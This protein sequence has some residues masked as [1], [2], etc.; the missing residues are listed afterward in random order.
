MPKHV[1][2]VKPDDQTSKPLVL[3]FSTSY[4]PLAGGAEIALREIALRLSN[5]FEFMILTART[6][7]ENAS[8]ELMPEGTVI[9]IGMGTFFDKWML[10]IIVP[11]RC[12]SIIR[13]AE[14]Q[15][16]DVILW[17]MDITQASLSAAILNRLVLA[18]PMILTIQYGEDEG[19][20]MQ[21]RLG[22]IRF[23]LRFLLSRADHVIAIS[24]YLL[25]LAHDHGYRGRESLIPN[26]VDVSKFENPS[27]HRQ[28]VVPTVI[29]TSRLVRKNGVDTLIRAIGEIVDRAPEIK[30]L[31]L[32]NGQLRPE[33]ETLTSD[34]GLDGQIEFLGDVAHAEVPAH[35]WASDIFVRPSRSEGMGNSFVEALAAGLP[36]IGTPVGGIPDIIRDGETGL[37]VRVDDPEDL[38]EKI[39][40]LLK[41]EGL[42]SRIVR[43]GKAMV[44]SIFNWDKIAEDYRVVFRSLTRK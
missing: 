27:D 34:L 44:E 31:V 5:D 38:A 8:E 24:N 33:L 7:R 21:G 39:E 30:C 15:G 22:L 2:M 19:H 29:T 14:H 36:I 12:L 11:F 1:S 41:D 26:G 35:L 20:L 18:V 23:S 6:H 13:K 28:H 43:N 16:R 3:A 9:R 32:G 40:L 10:P 17:G 42:S 4:F 25:K 37:F